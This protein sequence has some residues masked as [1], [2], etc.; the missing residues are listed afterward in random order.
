[1]SPI[2]DC[3]N[4]ILTAFSLAADDEGLISQVHPTGTLVPLKVEGRRLVLPTK[5]WQR[6]GYGEDYLPF[7][8]SCEVMSREGTS[9]VMQMLQRQAK[10][11]LA[12]A[13]VAMGGSLLSVA[14]DKETH[15]DLPLECSAFLKKLSNAD[16][17][18]KDLF[19][20]LIGAAV[21]K[22]R[23]LTVYLKNG[24]T[25]EGK[26]VNRSAIIRFPILEDLLSDAKDPLGVVIPKKQR[27]TLVALFQL[28]VP[29]G[30]K[31]E[32][33]S[34]GTTARVAPYLLSL[35]NAYHK[36]ASVMNVLIEQYADKLH[37]PVKA[38][39]LYEM[40]II[41]TITKHFGDI[42]PY[43]GNE[44][45]TNEQPSE[46]HETVAVAKKAAAK[47]NAAPVAKVVQASRDGK[48]AQLAPVET[49]V[50]TGRPAASMADFMNATAP[51]PAPVGFG[52]QQPQQLN[53]GFTPVTFNQ[54]QQPAY[55]P[56]SFAP[57]A[58]QYGFATPSSPYSPAPVGL[59]TWM[60]GQ[61]THNPAPQN[62][63][64]RAT[65]SSIAQ[66]NGST[67]LI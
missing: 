47:V 13:L 50:T 8:P 31:P 64:M 66:G 41:E 28:L 61:P 11:V 22:N 24:G 36:T 59:P 51:Q 10:A 18:T 19:D 34:F 14:V 45:A 40:S 53:T 1:M 17:N 32:E 48:S 9:P 2:L 16:K 57:P 5:A 62:P 58:P 6:K 7:H 23:L 39:D 44:G 67:G 15:K 4:S 56:V 63:F 20:K 25:Y 55:A 52:Q 49:A 43:S 29:N 54:P 35:L 46:A 33:Y 30:D 65:P 42:P 12:H 21:K 38:V 26:K 27:P 3:Y 37:I 60:G